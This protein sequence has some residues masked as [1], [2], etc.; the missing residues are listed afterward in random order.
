MTVTARAASVTEN[1]IKGLLRPKTA[2]EAWLS[3][4]NLY[5][6]PPNL[7]L[8]PEQILTIDARYTKD[9]PIE[10]DRNWEL[11]MINALRDVFPCVDATRGINP[12]FVV[13]RGTALTT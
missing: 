9:N 4:K 12:V 13:K 1:S 7:P 8:A 5:C 6:T 11:V 3:E 10:L 2:H